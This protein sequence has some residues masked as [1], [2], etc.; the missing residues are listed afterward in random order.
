MSRFTQFSLV[1]RTDESFRPS[2]KKLDSE[3]N[4]KD[5]TTVVYRLVMSKIGNQ[6]QYIDI[7]ETM[8]LVFR[9]AISSD[10][11][12]SIEQMNNLVVEKLVRKS[13]IHVSRQ[14]AFTKRTFENSNIPQN[15]LARPSMS[16]DK[17]EDDE[18]RGKFTIELQR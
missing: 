1:K 4:S 17:N 15:F 6:I 8:K 18:S 9:Q 10:D 7:V 16:I 12:P 2:E 5:N 13:E 3:F 11:H 14:Q